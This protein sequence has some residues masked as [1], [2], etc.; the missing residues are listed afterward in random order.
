MRFYESVR[1]L[2]RA[3]GVAVTTSFLFN[4]YARKLLKQGECIA[5]STKA[6]AWQKALERAA[7]SATGDAT[8][9]SDTA[10]CSA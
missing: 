3:R 6:K 2:A 4:D 1:A 10:E 9:P 8:D 7:E 5:S